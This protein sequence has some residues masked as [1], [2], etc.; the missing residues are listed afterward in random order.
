[1][2]TKER[3]AAIR[4]ELKAAGWNARKVS[5]RT[6][7]YSM[8]SSIHVTIRDTAADTAKVTE[9][10]ER[11]GQSISRC[12]MTGDILG[13]GNTYVHVD[14]STEVRE[15]HRS[16]YAAGVQ[17]A[18]D[19]LS[20]DSPNTLQPVAGFEDVCVGRS[21]NGWSYLLWIDGR[22]CR[23]FD[24]AGTGSMEIVLAVPAAKLTDAPEPPPEPSPGQLETLAAE[25]E[26]TRNR[27]AIDKRGCSAPR[28]LQTTP[29]ANGRRTDDNTD[30]EFL[31]GEVT[32]LRL[33]NERLR[34]AKTIDPSPVPW[35]VEFGPIAGLNPQAVYQIK[36]CRNGCPQL[37]TSK[38]PDTGADLDFAACLQ[39]AATYGPK[40]G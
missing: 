34:G 28:S 31:I 39:I 6:D 16:R 18:I 4:A 26:P 27:R 22:H 33:E 14:H 5:V 21:Q 15:F 10:A 17:A 35:D 7:Y 13:G 38:H 32:R 30:T 20:K 29:L 36:I 1:M 12:E 23:E 40:L 19:L 24:E 2:S 9:I 37:F 8:G 3:A 25:I 11:L